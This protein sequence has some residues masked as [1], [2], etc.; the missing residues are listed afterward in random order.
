MGRTVADRHGILTLR[1]PLI[2]GTENCPGECRKRQLGCRY[3]SKE[4]SWLTLARTGRVAAEIQ[5][6]LMTQALEVTR[7][8]SLY[9]IATIHSVM[10]SPYHLSQN[11]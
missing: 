11:I 7:R 3:F 6:S 9:E 4:R 8:V 5:Y 1:R 2:C 10:G